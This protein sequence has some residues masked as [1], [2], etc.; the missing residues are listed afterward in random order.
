MADA[1]DALGLVLDHHCQ[2]RHARITRAQCA[3]QQALVALGRRN[4]SMP[5]PCE[6][7]VQVTDEARARANKL[8]N[9]RVP[10]RLVDIDPP[11]TGGVPKETAMPKKQ[12]KPPAD[13]DRTC[14]LCHR[15]T[16][17]EASRNGVCRH[18]VK[19]VYAAIGPLADDD[20]PAQREQLYR[21]WEA[22]G[23][24]G[25]ERKRQRALRAEKSAAQQAPPAPAPAAKL[26]PAV[27]PPPR[28]VVDA[29]K[30][31]AEGTEVL[32]SMVVLSTPSGR[33]KVELEADGEMLS[34]FLANLNR[35]FERP[36][37]LDEVT[38]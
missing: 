31:P 5:C 28:E 13:T 8:V 29:D 30:A 16:V 26:H 1:P 9:T 18:C 27:A 10:P 21:A 15:H 4:Y 24:P 6:H 22:S 3:L 32:L 23:E 34:L 7:A 38:A 2:P 37:V 35:F 25:Y 11:T 17:T 14:W 20:T 19:K 33:V 12:S 36:L